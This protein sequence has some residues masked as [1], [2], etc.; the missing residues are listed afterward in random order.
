MS[1]R[2]LYSHLLTRLPAAFERMVASIVIQ[3]WNGRGA[4]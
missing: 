2:G 3:F 1:A 4:G